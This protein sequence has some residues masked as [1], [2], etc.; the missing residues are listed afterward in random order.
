MAKK[1]ESVPTIT[2]AK[3]DA[4]AND[5]NGVDIEGFPTIKFWRAD[6]K[7]QPIDYDGDRDID[8]FL[9]WLDEKAARPFGRSEL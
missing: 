9:S 3:I 2:I 1:L 7:E 4:T 5:V 6:N 8:S